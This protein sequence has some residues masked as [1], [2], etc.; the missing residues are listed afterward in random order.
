MSAASFWRKKVAQVAEELDNRLKKETKSVW[1]DNSTSILRK[2]VVIR[3]RRRENSHFS[4]KKLR[5]GLYI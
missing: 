2:E 1:K 5:I 3:S 4:T